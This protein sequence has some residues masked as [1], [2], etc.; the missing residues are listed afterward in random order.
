VGEAPVF[1]RSKNKQTENVAEK[2]VSPPGAEER[3]MHTVVKKDE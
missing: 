2:R 1:K 3:I